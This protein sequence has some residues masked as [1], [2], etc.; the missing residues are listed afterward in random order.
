MM[1]NISVIE[2]SVTQ[3]DNIIKMKFVYCKKTQAEC[4]RGAHFDV[5]STNWFFGVYLRK[6]KGDVGEKWLQVSFLW[7]ELIQK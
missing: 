5:S 3:S 2:F 4:C 7:F 1:E 6:S